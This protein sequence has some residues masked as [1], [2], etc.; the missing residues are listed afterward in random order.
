[1][2]IVARHEE[3]RTAEV[4]GGPPVDVGE[5]YELLK[6]PACK[7]INLRVTKWDEWAVEA[8]R[9]DGEDPEEVLGT[10]VYPA[11]PE[12]PD[13]LPPA[14]RSAYQEALG[15]RAIS[16]NAYSVLLGRVL[17]A[18]C[19]DRD[20][21]GDT[22]YQQIANLGK[23]NEIP[24]TIVKVAHGVRKFRNVGAHSAI[25]SLAATD[26]T[27]VERLARAVLEFVYTAPHLAKLA[28]QAK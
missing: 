11:P 22:L 14:I 5:E 1:M 13:G 3:S 12:I 6:C 19:R 26:V 25:G 28:E 17:E 16:P 24:E 18:V 27:V 15:V 2:E 9:D 4:T 8:I 7:E 21:S 20:A 10:V 23:K